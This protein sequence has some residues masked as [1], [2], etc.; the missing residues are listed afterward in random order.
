M[1]GDGIQPF[2]FSLLDNRAELQI[3]YQV[4]GMRNL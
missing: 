4:F 2:R 3:Y 1:K